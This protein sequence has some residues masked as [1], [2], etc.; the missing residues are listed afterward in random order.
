MWNGWKSIVHSHGIQ[1]G[2][3]LLGTQ[4]ST[5]ACYSSSLTVW[6]QIKPLVQPTKD[7]M[8]EPIR[9]FQWHEFFPHGIHVETCYFPFFLEFFWRSYFWFQFAA[10]NN[11]GVVIALWAP[12]ILVCVNPSCCLSKEV[13]STICWVL[14]VELSRSISWT[15]KFGMHFSLHWLVVSMGLIV[16]L[17][18][19]VKYFSIVLHY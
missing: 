17:V 5:S 14:S 18:R 8:R 9:T 11:I 3:S 10:N 15:P 4:L 6:L 7:I 19:L 16:V 1:L 13:V 12:I 2:P